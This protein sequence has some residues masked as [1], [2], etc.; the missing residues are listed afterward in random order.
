MTRFHVRCKSHC[1]QPTLNSDQLHLPFS[2]YDSFCAPL[3]GSLIPSLVQHVCQTYPVQGMCQIMHCATTP[4]QAHQHCF[5]D[6]ASQDIKDHAHNMQS[7]L[8]AQALH[9][10]G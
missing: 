4:W 1:W 5:P 7:T 6:D 9:Q 10:V 3:I 8:T 2:A